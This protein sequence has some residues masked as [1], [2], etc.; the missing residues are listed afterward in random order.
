MICFGVCRLERLR[1]IVPHAE[2]SN[3]ATFLEQ[4]YAHIEHLNDTISTLKEGIVVRESRIQE[5][6]ASG[7]PENTPQPIPESSKDPVN[8]AD[9]SQVAMKEDPGVETGD[10]GV[11]ANTV[12]ETALPPVGEQWIGIKDGLKR[13]PIHTIQDP[14][15]RLRA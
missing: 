2:R 8:R 11:Q 9:A 6:M 13:S 15:K 4:V 7:R 3:T 10:V 5:L 14:A 1:T 12:A